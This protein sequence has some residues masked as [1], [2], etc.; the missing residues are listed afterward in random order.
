MVLP[1][2]LGVPVG[3]CGVPKSIGPLLFSS[4]NEYFG[5]LGSIPL[6]VPTT[7]EYELL[8]CPV[9][10]TLLLRAQLNVLFAL[11]VA[12]PDP[13]PYISLPLRL[14]AGPLAEYLP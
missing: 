13:A 10:V 1:D 4:L 2:E 3:D 14:V 5:A 11:S 12:L 7:I 9:Q 6:Q 8:I